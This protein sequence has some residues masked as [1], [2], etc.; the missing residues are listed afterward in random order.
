[1]FF[2]LGLSTLEPQLYICVRSDQVFDP[3][4][5]V[6]SVHSLQL[7]MDLGITVSVGF[8]G[9]A[10]RTEGGRAKT[11]MTENQKTFQRGQ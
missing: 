6:N 8:H 11:P 9:E 4:D 3:I 1:M 5:L 2:R 10:A 7:R